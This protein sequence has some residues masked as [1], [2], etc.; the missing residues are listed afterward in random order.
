MK[1]TPQ[2]ISETPSIID[3]VEHI[4]L[5]APELVGLTFTEKIIKHRNFNLHIE[6]F[7]T[8]ERFN[9]F[10]GVIMFQGCFEKKQQHT[11]EFGE[12][13]YILKCSKKL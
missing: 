7:N 8:K 10:D 5:Y 11:D 6:P 4:L 13:Y 1:D 9:E 3:K 2:Q 12:T